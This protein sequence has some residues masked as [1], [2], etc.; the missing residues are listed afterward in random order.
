MSK[1]RNSQLQVRS[2]GRYG[3]DQWPQDDPGDR[4][5]PT[6]QDQ[7]VEAKVKVTL[8]ARRDE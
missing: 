6:D 2:Q 4:R 8:N 5:R 1:R 3:A 7:P